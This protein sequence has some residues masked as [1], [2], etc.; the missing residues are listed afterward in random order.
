MSTAL[1]TLSAKDFTSDQEVR[2]C[3]GCGDYAILA[4]VRKALPKLDIK[5][6]EYVFVSGIGCAARFPYYMA[7]Y[8]MHSI[9][10]RAPAFATGIKLANPHLDVWIASGDG[11]LL[12]IGGNHTLHL[13]RRNVDVNVLLFNNRIYGLT[14]GQYSPTSEFGK[15]T[16]STPMG[17]I[18]YPVNP[19]T[20][21]IG[22]GCTFVARTIDVEMKHLDAMLVAA[23]AHRGT[24]LVEIYQDCNIFNHQAFFYASQKDTKAETTVVLEHGKPLVFAE[25]TKGIRL[26]P[27]GEARLEVVELGGS[28]TEADLL[29]HDEHDRGFAFLL[30]QMSYPDFPEAVGIL[31]RDA[32]RAPYDALV[33]SQLHDAESKQGAGDLEA[34]LHEGDTWTVE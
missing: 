19:L 25:G 8:G 21:A 14:K 11:D 4:A 1:P 6:E 28:V 17:S 24:A 16:K 29:V 10:G 20:L 31:Y 15:K 2:W 13:M 22:A 32:G 12:S 27:G 9:H 18:D 3:P 7:T 30:A 33:H 34:L 26:V 23:A 5:R